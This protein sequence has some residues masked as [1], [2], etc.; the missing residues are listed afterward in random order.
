MK[1]FTKLQREEILDSIDLR[2]DTITDDHESATAFES[3]ESLNKL[4]SKI[5]AKQMDLTAG[6]IEWINEELDWKLEIGYAAA[7]TE[8]G[9]AAQGWIN[10]LQNAKDKL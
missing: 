1:L 5:E 3:E 8:V 7:E 4:K 9:F 10:S 6:E 2:L